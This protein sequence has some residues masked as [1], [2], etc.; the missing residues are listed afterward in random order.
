MELTKELYKYK[1]MNDKCK[2]M[3]DYVDDYERINEP[4]YTKTLYDFSIC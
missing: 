2:D 3:E 1:E 4:I